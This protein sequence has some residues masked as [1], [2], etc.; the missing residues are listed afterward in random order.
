LSTIPL[1]PVPDVAVSGRPQSGLNYYVARTLGEVLESWGVVYGAYLRD[2]L[3]DPN[4]YGIH[5][6]PQA[7]GPN[8]AVTFGCLGPLPV[9][10]LSAYADGP[11]GLPLET[12][13]HPQIQELRN[14]GRKLI[15]VGL[16][17]D[18]RE[19]LNR[20]AEGLFELMRFGHYFGAYMEADDIIIG[21]HPRHAPFY[22]RFFG[23]KQIGPVKT[24]P[25]VKDKA[26]VLLQ[27]G[28]KDNPKLRPLPKG[29]AYFLENPISPTLFDR[30]FRFDAQAVA[31][32][33]I[34]KFLAERT[35]KAP[36][37][38]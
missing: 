28:I 11:A 22:I 21:V 20:S 23:C 6:V 19:H 29:L 35:V 5:T 8:T 7:V 36:T 27:F 4:P 15:E 9:S 14:A 17:A 25:T 24:Y 16:F 37:A 1:Q 38:A 33:P 34:G 18:R 3:I 12:V 32:S 31:A 2:D 13:Y 10:A 26:V 30:R